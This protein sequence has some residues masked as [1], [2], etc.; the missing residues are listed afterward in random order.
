MEFKINKKMGYLFFAMLAFSSVSRL[1]GQNLQFGKVKLI[2]STRDTVPT[3]KI[4]K[5]E[6]LIYSQAIANCPTNR[7]SV[8]IS[9]SILINGIQINVRAQRFSG[10]MDR[11]ADGCVQS[12]SV[13]SPEFV[14]W[15]QKLP[16]WL[17]AGTTISA[18]KGVQYISILEFA[19]AP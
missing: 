1:S 15:E 3:G 14:I 6:G 18:S 5:V 9:D 12:G 16:F 4:W 19:E 7:F 8:N 13:F 17:P 10:L 2:G 11:C